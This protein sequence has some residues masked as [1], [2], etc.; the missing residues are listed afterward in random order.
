MVCLRLQILMAGRQGELIHNDNA[1][2]VI[3]YYLIFKG[4]SAGLRLIVASKQPTSWAHFH[5]FK[6][7]TL[8]SSSGAHRIHSPMGKLIPWPLHY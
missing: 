4:H 6:L 7:N 5:M 2:T 1:L 3:I 8:A